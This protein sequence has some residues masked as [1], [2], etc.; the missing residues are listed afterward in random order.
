[1]RALSVWIVVSAAVAAADAAQPGRDSRDADALVARVGVKVEEFYARA[2]TVTSRETVRLQ[3]L[4]S[5][6]RPAGLARQLV[7][8]LRVAWEPSSDG[9]PPPEASVLRQLVTVNGRPP[10]PRD[11]PQCMD[12]K[13]VAP[14]TLSMLLPHNRDD[15]EFSLAGQGRIDDRPSITIDFRSVSKEPPEVVWEESCVH[16]TIPGRTRGRIWIDA[17]TLDVLRIDEHLTG[18]FDFRTSSAIARRTGASYMSLERY[19]SSIRYRAV[20]F[21]DPEETLTLPRVIETT[22]VW[23]GPGILRNRMTQQFSDYR[24]FITGARIVGADDVR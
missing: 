1:M 15:Y 5:D 17:A 21:E 18:L 2:R 9:G 4:E 22:S 24:R 14:D 19:D 20:K 23:R 12:P 7:Y 13:D 11:E 10:R 16:V 8:D 3:Q 6:F